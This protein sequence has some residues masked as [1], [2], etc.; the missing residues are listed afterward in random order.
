MY[1][2]LI[3]DD[4]DALKQKIK[5]LCAGHACFQES[6]PLPADSPH[7]CISTT[8]GIYN[9]P[10]DEILFIE[11]RQKKSTIHLTSG[12]LTLPVPLYR[13]RE[14]LPASDFMQTHRSFIV[15]LKNIAY[16]DKTKDTWVIFSFSSDKTAFIS[17]T[18]R[19]DV[20]V[21]IKPTL[22]CISD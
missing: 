1:T 10:L 13:L 22:Y 5:A 19:R 4:D 12:V 15:N 9:I 17:R 8:K 3:A 16:I 6:E 20:M 18:Y 2:I 11:S 21:A 7:C 14:T